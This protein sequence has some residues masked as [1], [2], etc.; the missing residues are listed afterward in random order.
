MRDA[1]ADCALVAHR[2]IGNAGGNLAHRAFERIRRATVLDLRV[3]DRGAD[4][5]ALRGGLNL[6][7][8]RDRCDV[9]E[10]PWTGEAQVQHRTQ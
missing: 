8:H 5:Y 3:G 1:A 7:Q 4:D 6:S 2:A 10:L 9:D